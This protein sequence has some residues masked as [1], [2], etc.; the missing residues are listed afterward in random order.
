MSDLENIGIGTDIENI[1]KFKKID[2]KFLNKVFT[3]NEIR[4]CYSTGDAA[5]HF[6]A[7]FSGKEAVFKALSSIGQSCPDYRDIE[8]LKD[9]NGV[10]YVKL[11]DEELKNILVKISLSHCDDKVASFAITIKK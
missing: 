10:P 7:R 9:N 11:H 6:A 2:E 8:I 4:Y 5:S 1:S 3:K